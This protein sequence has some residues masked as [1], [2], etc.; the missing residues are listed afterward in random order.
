MHKAVSGA[1]EWLPFSVRLY[2]YGGQEAIRVVHT[3]TF[4]GDQEKD[5]IR[6]L[7]LT[8][9]VPLREGLQNRHVRFTGADG[10]L[11]AE[12]IQAGAGNPT[13]AAGQA[14]PSESQLR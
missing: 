14:I 3:I 9:A 1:R 5:F 2:F 13:Q 10:G 11:W 8:F 7:G 4:D 12:P 6:G